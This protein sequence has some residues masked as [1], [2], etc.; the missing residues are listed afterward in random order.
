MF[1]EQ[2]G[3]NRK[4]FVKDYVVFDLETTGL[5]SQFDQ[6][7]EIS[8][9]KVKNHE[10]VDEFTSLVNP[11]RPIPDEASYV[12]GITDSMVKDAPE[13]RQVLEEFSAF[14]EELVLVGHNIY[15]FDLPFLY[16]DAQSYWGRTIGNDFVDTLQMARACLPGR[17]GYGLG[18]LAEHYGIDTAGAHR[19]LADCH[20]TQKVYEKLR[21]E[22]DKLVREGQMRIC[23]QCGSPMVIRRGPTGGFW[24]CL[25]YPECRCTVN[26]RQ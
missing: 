16:R 9:V 25:R 12:N 3:R 15:R 24:G 23:A 11:G 17:R 26:I 7:I 5:S 19:A 4:T 1:A 22:Q 10:V 13:F 2:P 21:G 14:S 18:S 20:M 8:G 6:V